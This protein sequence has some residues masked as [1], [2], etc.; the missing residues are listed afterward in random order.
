[1]WQRNS[2][3]KGGRGVWEEWFLQMILEMLVHRT[4]PSCIAANILTIANSL[5]PNCDAVQALPCVSVVRECRS[6]LLV[7]TKTLAAYQLALVPEYLQHHSDGT[8]RRQIKMESSILRIA[9]DAGFKCVTLSSCILPEDGTAES[10]V[11]AIAQAFREGR[12][13]LDNWRDVTS[14]MYP[15]RPDFLALIPSSSLLTLA[16]LSNKSLLMTDTC[17]TAR[18]FRRLFADHTRQVDLNNGI[19]D[20]Q[21]HIFQADC[22]QHLRNVWFGAVIKQLSQRLSEVLES[23]LNE[24]SPFLRVTTEVVSL[25]IALEKYFAETANYAKG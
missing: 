15:N 21:I 1:M 19:P 17:A 22:W 6:V 18:K 20:D 2:H 14:R 12:E 8:E 16:K 11:T 23:D 7:T 3:G 24:I 4:P 5:H 9:T 10:C 25:L 13:L